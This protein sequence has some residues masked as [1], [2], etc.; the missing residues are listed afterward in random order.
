MMTYKMTVS[1]VPFNLR[2][3][4]NESPEVGTSTAHPSTARRGWK[5]RKGSCHMSRVGHK[6]RESGENTSE[7]LKKPEFA[8]IFRGKKFSPYEITIW[9]RQ[10]GGFGISKKM[11]VWIVNDR[12]SN[13]L[14]DLG[15]ALLPTRRV[16]KE[17][18]VQP[19]RDF[20][21]TGTV[22]SWIKD[23]WVYL[24][25]GDVSQMFWTYP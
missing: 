8:G 12:W 9:G 16:T 17:T 7:I 18:Y 19:T 15:Q 24:N 3:L 22:N 1:Q 11:A 25:L 13:D 21:D 2:P 4:L 23:K 5:L 20:P 14:I 10:N 6:C